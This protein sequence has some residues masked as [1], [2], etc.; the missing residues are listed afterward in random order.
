MKPHTPTP[1]RSKINAGG[2]P[3]ATFA[4]K[5]PAATPRSTGQAP[6][7]SVP[8]SAVRDSSSRVSVLGGPGPLTVEIAPGQFIAECPAALAP[9]IGLVDWQPA[10]DGT[11]RPVVRLHAK[12]LRLTVKLPAQLGLGVSYQTLKQLIR[13][14]FVDG[15]RIAPGNYEFDLQSYFDHRSGAKDP[16]FWTTEIEVRIGSQ[17]V[18][19]TRLRIYQEAL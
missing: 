17:T 14:G 6:R 2:T 12:R 7:A 3:A 16:E 5:K 10:G 15:T 13:A 19:K 8:R 11:F 4:G 1:Q 18:R 9:R